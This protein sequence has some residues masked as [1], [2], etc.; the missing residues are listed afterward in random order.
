MGLLEQRLLVGDLRFEAHHRELR[1]G[2]PHRIDHLVGRL[3]LD[4]EGAARFDLRGCRLG[5]VVA[6]RGCGD[7]QVRRRRGLDGRLGHLCGGLHRDDLRVRQR[8]PVVDHGDVRTRDG[9]G[10]CDR[11]PGRTGCTVRQHADRVDRLAGRPRGDDHM[12]ACQGPLTSGTRDGGDDRIGRGDLRFPLRQDGVDEVDPP[13]CECRQRLRGAG[14]VVH[15]RVHRRSDDHRHPRTDRRLCGRRHGGV[16][17][18]GG[19]LAHRVRRRGRDEQHIGPPISTAQLDVLDRPRDLGDDGGL[20]G[21]LDGPRVDDPRRIGGHHPPHRGAA[22]AQLVDEFDHPHRG[23]R[24]GD[25]DRDVRALQ[26]ILRWSAGWHNAADDPYAF[27]P[28]P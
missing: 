17:D 1:C 4:G 10:L 23:D 3:E 8:P 6:H 21:E 2:R 5:G 22:A 12:L 27:A 15:G 14:V 24:S 18:R 7:E 19:E 9:G 28:Q 16:V 20:G 26:H 25:P 11:P 13:L